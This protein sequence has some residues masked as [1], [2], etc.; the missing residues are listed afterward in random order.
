MVRP[1]AVNGWRKPGLVLKVSADWVTGK[2]LNLNFS[3]THSVALVMY[4]VA[5]QASCTATDVEVNTPGRDG[6]DLMSP[7]EEDTVIN[8]ELGVKLHIAM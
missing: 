1:G 6:E 3:K 5:R 8:V 7:Y 2:N 4:T